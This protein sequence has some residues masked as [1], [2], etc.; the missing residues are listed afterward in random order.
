[1]DGGGVVPIESQWREREGG[2]EGGREEGEGGYQFEKKF[3]RP[4]NT[5]RTRRDQKKSSTTPETS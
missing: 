4:K 1:V 3:Y 2:R 5:T